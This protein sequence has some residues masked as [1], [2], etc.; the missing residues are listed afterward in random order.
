MSLTSRDSSVFIGGLFCKPSAHMEPNRDVVQWWTRTKLSRCNIT[1]PSWSSSQIHSTWNYEINSTV[2]P[3]AT[4]WSMLTCVTYGCTIGLQHLHDAS[5]P[6][7]QTRENASFPLDL[8][9]SYD[10]LVNILL[11][12]FLEVIFK[13]LFILISNLQKSLVRIFQ[14]QFECFL[15]IF[16]LLFIFVFCF[17]SNW[18][19]P[20]MIHVLLEKTI[21]YFIV[22]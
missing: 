1:I 11:L 12:T 22:K 10:N 16:S 9:K 2:C 17:T 19:F 4:N 8:M 7:V 5:S 14:L 13:T 6:S 3:F 21:I 18:G 15:L 20:L